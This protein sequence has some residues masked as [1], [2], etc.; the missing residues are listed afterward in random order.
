MPEVESLKKARKMYCK[1]TNI[2]VTKLNRYS[3]IFMSA[4]KMAKN[5]KEFFTGKFLCG[6]LKKACCKN[7]GIERFWLKRE[8]SGSCSCWRGKSHGAKKVW[9]SIS[10]DLKNTLWK[11]TL[12]KIHSRKIHFQSRKG[13]SLRAKKV[14]KSI[15]RDLPPTSFCPPTALDKRA[16]LRPSWR[17]LSPFFNCVI[18]SR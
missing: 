8:E 16:G 1:Y 3:P 4:T 14:W 10:R 12:S 18:I 2:D 9:K 6:V 5:L 15:S 13:K 7:L 17:S 11:S